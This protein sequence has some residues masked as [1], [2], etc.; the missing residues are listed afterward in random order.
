MVAD[1]AADGTFYGYNYQAIGNN[2]QIKKRVLSPTDCS[3]GVSNVGAPITLGALMGQ[4]RIVVIRGVV[5][6]LYADQ[7]Y[8]LKFVSP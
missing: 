1:P 2:Y 5:G 6:L 7:T 3:G 4:P 8:L